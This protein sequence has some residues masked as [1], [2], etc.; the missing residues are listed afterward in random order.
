LKGKIKKPPKAVFLAKHQGRFETDNP[1]ADDCLQYSRASPYEG[2]KG[3][4]GLATIVCKR[5]SRQTTGVEYSVRLT[6]V[7]TR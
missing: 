7:V 6:S 5:L 1:K 2:T 3:D 4:S